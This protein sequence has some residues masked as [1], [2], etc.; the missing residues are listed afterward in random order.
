VGWGSRGRPGQRHERGIYS[1][2]KTRSGGWR[3]WTIRVTLPIHR[4]KVNEHHQGNVESNINYRRGR[5]EPFPAQKDW[6]PRAGPGCTL[7]FR[8]TLPPLKPREMLT[9]Q[10][11][12]GRGTGGGERRRTKREFTEGRAIPA[13]SVPNQFCFFFLPLS[14]L[15]LCSAPSRVSPSRLPSSF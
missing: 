3:T 10:D 12:E 14:L 9:K 11:T 7:F 5:Q 15:F 8:V 4:T 1:R 2:E 13:P 6:E